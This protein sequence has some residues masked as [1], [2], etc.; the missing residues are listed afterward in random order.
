M[1]PNKEYIIPFVGLKLGINEFEYSIDKKFF[2]EFEYSLVKNGDVKVHLTFNKQETMFMLDFVLKGTIEVSCDRCLAPYPQ[3]IETSERQIF[4]ISDSEINDEG[5]IIVISRA[6][7]ELDVAPLIYEYI[8]LQVPI[9]TNCDGEK[10]YCDQEMLDKLKA[11]RTEDEESD[12][13]PSDPRWDALKNF[14]DN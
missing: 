7:Y 1:K 4:K 9:I 8:N 5:E 13:K 6:A 3:D 12:E 2:D 10:S 14:R 11:L